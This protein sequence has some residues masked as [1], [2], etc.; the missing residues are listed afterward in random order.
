MPQLIAGIILLYVAFW[1]AVA[2]G[3]IYITFLAIRYFIK[4]TEESMENS[5]IQAQLEKNREEEK[6]EKLR[7]LRKEIDTVK[8]NYE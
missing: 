1:V 2:C 6:R 5:R 8:S 3:A 7:Q 4:M